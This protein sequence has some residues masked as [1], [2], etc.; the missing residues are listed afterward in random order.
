[1]RIK[2]YIVAQTLEEAYALNQSPSS[3]ILGGTGW[4]KMQNRTITKAI[5]LSQLH[6]DEIKETEDSFEVGAMVTLRDLECHQ[7][8]QALCGGAIANG[9]KG[10][11]GVQ[12]RNCAT[13]G[14]SIYSRFGFSDVL[15]VLLALNTQVN[16]YKQG[17]VSLAD[18]ATMSYDR[19]IVVSISIPKASVVVAYETF[20]VQATDLPV[21]NVAVSKNPDGKMLVA[22]GARPQR[23]KVLA[24]DT[25]EQAMACGAMFTYGSNHRGK[26]AY[27]SHLA[28]VLIKRAVTAVMEGK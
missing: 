19:D 23:A 18:Y 21:L 4:L 12:F 20:R 7:G 11:V 9:V 10:I 22:V 27:R 5:D 25:P 6:L 3:Q 15:T 17:Q 13:V 8:L 2:N 26:A 24:F 14:G 28:D 1:L 16:L